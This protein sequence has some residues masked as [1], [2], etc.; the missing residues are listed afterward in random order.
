MSSPMRKIAKQVVGIV[1]I[2]AAT[3]YISHIASQSWPLV[4]IHLRDVRWPLL[5]WAWLLFG[6][7][8]M[9]RVTAWWLLLKIFGYRIPIA[10]SGEVWFLSEMTRYIPGNVWSFLSRTYLADKE[11]IPKRIT[12]ASLTIEIIFLVGTSLVFGAIFVLLVPTQAHYVRWLFLLVLPLLL[13]L[14]FPR[15]LGIY[16]NKLLFLIKRPSI[17]FI[18]SRAELLIILGTFLLAWL[19]YGAGSY[20]VMLSFVGHLVPSFWLFVAGFVL[21]WL[22]G[23]L[24]FVTPMGLGVREGFLILILSPF[25]SSPLAILVAITTRIWLI[26]SECS[27]LIVIAVKF[28]SQHWQLYIM[29]IKTWLKEHWEV[30]LLGV[31]TFLFIGYF[32][33]FTFLRHENFISSR[34]DLGIMDQVVWNTAHGHFFKLT[35]PGGDT[36]VSRFSIHADIFLVL[37]APLYWIISS[38]YVLLFLQVVVVALGAL[39]IFWLGREVLKSQF[40]ALLIAFAYLM[41]PPLQRA[42]IFDFHAVTLA[43]TFL[44]FAFYYL[45]KKQYGWF[46]LFALLTLSTKETMAFLVIMLGIYSIVAQKNWRIGIATIGLS[47]LWFYLLL[48]HIMPSIRGDGSAHFA[49]SYYSQFGNSPGAIIHTVL[50]KPRVWIPYLLTNRQLHYVG[51]FLVPTGFLAILSPIFFLATPELL[52]NMLSNDWAMKTFYFQYTSGITPF[53]FI[54]LIFGVK[55]FQTLFSWL[56]RKYRLHKLSTPLVR[57]IGGYLLLSTGLTTWLWSPLPGM[58]MS[59]TLP[60]HYTI[61]SKD[62][63][64]QLQKIIPPTAA[65]SAT[66]KIEPHFSERE[67]VYPF[68][69][70]VGKSDYILVEEGD[71][72]EVYS[73]EIIEQGV[74]ALEKDPRYQRIY[75][76]D[77]VQVFKKKT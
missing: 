54:A 57:L 18:A 51:F 36:T 63:L 67:E 58:R 65:V 5:F 17:T 53:V 52:L 44:L 29:K 19:A 49:L 23:Y 20:L 72:Y 32:L 69:L 41:F 26:V 76:N 50:F 8:F 3:F 39:P 47:G 35:D 55:N 24:S 11:K 2:V 71:Q 25:L 73:T 37:L 13:V 62:Y 45:Y 22:V 61:P 64:Y 9:A 40:L 31:A 60:F 43:T 21:A 66:A 4:A 70:G 1:F 48:W 14:L 7:Y 34:F 28:L 10:K 68:P 74:R 12:L 59:D 15:L 75:Q 33:S 38:P 16:I 42:V 46:T 6:I 27:F 30:S 56:I 77:R